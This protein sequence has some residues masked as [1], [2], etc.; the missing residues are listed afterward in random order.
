MLIET[1][2]VDRTKRFYSNSARL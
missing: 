2:T 1:K